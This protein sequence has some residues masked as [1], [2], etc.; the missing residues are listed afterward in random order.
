MMRRVAVK[1]FTMEYIWIMSEYRFLPLYSI[2]M[3]HIFIRII[4]RYDLNLKG[5]INPPSNL[6]INMSS[7][8]PLILNHD[9]PVSIVNTIIPFT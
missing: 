7:M 3:T 8:I 2:I 4:I 5:Q 6:R 9:I 1:P